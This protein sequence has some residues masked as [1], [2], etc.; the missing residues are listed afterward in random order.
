MKMASWIKPKMEHKKLVTRLLQ[1]NA[2][3]ILCFRAEEKIEIAKEGG[4]TVVRPKQSLVGLD[5]W[6]PVA[7]KNLPYEMTLSVLLTADSPACPKPIKLPEQFRS[8]VPL[9]KPLSEDVGTQLASWAAGAV[10]EPEPDSEE[11]A[12]LRGRSAVRQ[13]ADG[14]G[15][16]RREAADGA[17]AALADHP[18]QQRDRR[19]GRGRSDPARGLVNGSYRAHAHLRRLHGELWPR[20]RGTMRSAGMQR[21]CLL[22]GGI[23]R[24]GHHPPGGRR[25]HRSVGA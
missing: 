11:I 18:A 16:D 3:V 22:G 8:M 9:D 1:I 20:P 2:H 17:G 14:R 12:G 7:E 25:P 13:P 4:K 24:A 5:G 10:P 19:D 6:V 15:V 23:R 21:P